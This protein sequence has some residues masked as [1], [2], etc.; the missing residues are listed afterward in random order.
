MLKDVHEVY[1]RQLSTL[2]AL[3]YLTHKKPHI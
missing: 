1:S 2:Y 3:H